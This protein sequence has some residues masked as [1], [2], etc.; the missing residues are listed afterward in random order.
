M[1]RSGAPLAVAVV[2]IALSGCP[3]T[4]SPPIVPEEQPTRPAAA[5]ADTCEPLEPPP[6]MR[7]DSAASGDMDGDGRPDTFAL[8]VEEGGDV[9]R[10]VL[11]RA[12]LADGRVLDLMLDAEVHSATAESVEV[13][14]LTDA[15]GDGRDEGFAIL[16]RGASTVF[17]GI[18]SIDDGVLS[19]VHTTDGEPFAIAAGG[20][21]THG[22]GGECFADGELVLR[23]LSS[24]QA[25][26]YRWTE[27]T[28]RWVDGTLERV[29]TDRGTFDDPA[30]AELAP[31]YRFTCHDIEMR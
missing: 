3:G 13:V 9:E 18:F 17:A 24:R 31:F 14:G 28:Y 23:A 15:D 25:G 7:C 21:V 20:S 6:G 12:V 19:R 4:T 22:D 8:F 26:G 1:K 11:A 10:G 16:H 27:E 5:G 30:D 2:L 29:A